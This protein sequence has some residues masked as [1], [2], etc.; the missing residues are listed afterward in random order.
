MKKM[1]CTMLGLIIV[2]MLSAGAMAENETAADVM[3][4]W[5]LNSV[6]GSDGRV[7]TVV[8]NNNTRYILK[9]NADGTWTADFSDDENGGLWKK[10]DAEYVLTDSEE[11]AYT[12]L[13]TD[14]ILS[15]VVGD[16]KHI[17][18]RVQSA[19]FTPGEAIANP[20][21]EDFNGV[22]SLFMI[23]TSGFQMSTEDYDLKNSLTI[24]NGSIIIYWNNEGDVTSVKRE[25]TLTDDILKVSS[26]ITFKLYDEKKYISWIRED[27]STYYFEKISTE[28]WY[29]NSFVTNEIA[30][31]AASTDF[32]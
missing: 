29:A 25:G 21:L 3:G 13:L 11:T 23:E 16:E 17:F 6:I 18:S 8:S 10:N 4:V 9:I 28:T 2:L 12:F 15:Y 27:G 22:W 14:G 31:N 20:I 7:F 1:M 32:A 19:F 30:F 26:E 24:E 5:Y